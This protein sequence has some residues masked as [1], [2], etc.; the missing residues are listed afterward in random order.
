MRKGFIMGLATGLTIAG[1]SLVLANSQIQAIL[2]DQIKVTLNGQ[3]QEFK[4]ETTNETQ[5]PITYKDRT[6]LPLRTVADLVG[7]DVDYDVKTNTA[8]LFSEEID[9]DKYVVENAEEKKALIYFS[10]IDEEFYSYRVAAVFEDGVYYELDLENESVYHKYNKFKTLK[11]F[12]NYIIDNGGYKNRE[13]LIYEEIVEIINKEDE[14][15]ECQWAHKEVVEKIKDNIEHLED[16]IEYKTE[17]ETISVWNSNNQKIDLYIYEENEGENT[18]N[19]AKE[20][21]NNL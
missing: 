8:K 14:R 3:L 4:D 20:I 2:N 6:Y 18:T 17:R 12:N 13:N 15:F 10:E 1:T 21:L 19:V 9:D 5:Y 16:S 7:V 11:D